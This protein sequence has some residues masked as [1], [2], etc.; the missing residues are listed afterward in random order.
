MFRWLRWCPPVAF[1]VLF[2]LSPQLAVVPSSSSNPPRQQTLALDFHQV[3]ALPMASR[4]YRRYSHRLPRGASWLRLDGKRLL[5]R[6]HDGDTFKVIGPWY[7]GAK[8]RLKGYNTLENY[9]PVHKWGKWKPRALFHV[10]NRGTAL[11]RSKEWKCALMPGRGGYGRLLVNCYGLAKA[12]VSKGLAHVFS[13]RGPGD[14]AL[15]KAQKKAIKRRVGIWKKGVPAFIMTSVHSFS[16]RYNRGYNRLISTRD[17]HSAP[18]IHHHRYRVCQW[19]CAKGSCMLHVP[20]RQR[21]GPT[22]AS[23]L[24]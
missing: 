14:K 12:L 17:G 9:G 6:W 22:K 24:K 3:H 4:F 1:G 18:M 19:V 16:R 8:A 13:M 21:F 23:C 20:Y 7:R 2:W 11:A 15:V 5:V 10:G